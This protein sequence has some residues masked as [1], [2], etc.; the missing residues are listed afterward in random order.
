MILLSKGIS[1][2]YVAVCV[3]VISVCVHVVSVCMCGC[4]CAGVCAHVHVC[5]YVCTMCRW[6]LWVIMQ[7][8]CTCGQCVCVLCAVGIYG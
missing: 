4:V 8:V 3:C 7:C 6:N 5:L 1:S 2:Y